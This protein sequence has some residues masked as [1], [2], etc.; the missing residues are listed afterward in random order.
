MSPK[1]RKSARHQLAR[2]PHCSHKL[3]LFQDCVDELHRPTL[4][5]TVPDTSLLRSSSMYCHNCGQ[6]VVH[7]G[8]Y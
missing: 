6:Y 7:V 4:Y 1:A 5:R 8:G 2:C 3:Q